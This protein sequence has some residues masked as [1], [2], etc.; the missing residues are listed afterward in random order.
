V[1]LAAVLYVAGT[2]LLTGGFHVPRNDALA[3]LD[4]SAPGSAEQWATYVREWTA[5]N[6][7]R[8]LAGLGSSALLVG[9][10]LR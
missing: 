8:A 3:A 10:L 4:P 5:A 7:L 2:V 9:S 1:V 6:H